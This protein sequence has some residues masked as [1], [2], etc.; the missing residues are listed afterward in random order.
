MTKRRNCRP[1]ETKEPAKEAKKVFKETPCE[2][3]AFPAA[4]SIALPSDGVGDAEVVE[5]IMLHA[6]QILRSYAMK[7]VRSESD[8]K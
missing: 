7:G 4:E 3:W 1:K 8:Q 2:L 6:G 5:D